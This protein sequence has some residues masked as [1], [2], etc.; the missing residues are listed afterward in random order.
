M[1]IRLTAITDI[2]KMRTNN[3]DAVTLCAD[4]E[5]QLWGHGGTA[6]N[7]YLGRY[8]AM[9]IVA[10]GMGGANAGEVAS[11]IAVETI[12]GFFSVERM[13]AVEDGITE[14]S[15]S[16]LLVQAIALADN[17]IKNRAATAS[18][19]MGMGTTVVIAWIIGGKVHVA[20]C[21]D[22]RCY[23]FNPKT[24]LRRLTKDHS[25]VQEL[26]DNGEITEEQAFC[27]PDSNVIT[28]GL[29]DIE[30]SADPDVT[31]YPLQDGD[32]LLLCSD[33][34]CGYCNDR[35]IER[36]L[37]VTFDDLPLCQSKLLQLALN[38]GGKDNITIALAQALPEGKQ[39]PAV[40]WL[41]K[42]K[43]FVD[44]LKNVLGLAL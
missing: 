11:S 20:W 39:R 10:D 17:A 15:A 28:N 4:L 35:S 7:I 3:E 42:I 18:D 37:M 2:G 19:V 44:K 16:A 21:G 33:G 41:T 1:D 43:R 34:L 14:A 9:L 38:S 22:S 29:G 26:V 40:S 32:T 25:Y 8:G 24:G 31:T 36:V 13:A 5:G 23:L 12:A 27:H 6:D 30:A